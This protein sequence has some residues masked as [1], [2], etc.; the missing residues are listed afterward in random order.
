[1][2][3]REEFVPTAMPL[4]AGGQV[5]HVGEPVA[6]VVADDP[7]LAE[8]AAELVDV[9]YAAQQPA[10]ASLDAARAA[11]ARPVHDGLAGNC[12]VDLTMFDDDRLPDDLRRRAGGGRRRCQ[13]RP[14]GRAAR[15]RAGPAWPSGT[16]G[17]A[18][19]C[20]TSPPRSR[21]RSGPPW[22]R[23][24]RIP[25]RAVRVIA[26]DVGGG[27]GLKCVVGREELA[28]A[29]AG[30]AAAPAGRAGPRTGRRT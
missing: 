12:L 9:D 17:T 29:A 20:C 21:T 13:Q 25:E 4:L 26:P 18:S 11:G 7:Y 8:D 19:S 24:L 30:P 16:T 23:R 3:E 5:R 15:W 14:A 27:F 10:V 22:R 2:L 28:V 6:V 1:M